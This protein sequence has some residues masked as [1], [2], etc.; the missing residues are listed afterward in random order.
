M[1][2]SIVGMQRGGKLPDID[3]LP[4]ILV[5]TDEVAAA[6]PTEHLG[7]LDTGRQDALVAEC[8]GRHEKAAASPGDHLI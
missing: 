1:D 4:W 2:P 8:T 5:V 6:R 7:V 3:F